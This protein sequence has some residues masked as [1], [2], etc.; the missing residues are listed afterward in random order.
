MTQDV[1]VNAFFE[2]GRACLR[3]GFDMGAQALGDGVAAE[4][5]P[6]AGAEQRVS[7]SSGAFV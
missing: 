6:G 2:Q 1:R 7:W 5:P 4:A 3:G